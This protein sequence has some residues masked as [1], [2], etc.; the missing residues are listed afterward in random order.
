MQYTRQ[1]LEYMATKPNG[2]ATTK[3]LRKKF[4]DLTS[5][6]INQALFMMRKNGKATRIDWGTW[7]AN[8]LTPVNKSD[9]T[10]AEQAPTPTQSKPTTKRKPYNGVKSKEIDQLKKRLDEATQEILHWHKVV[11]DSEAMRQ[12][13]NKMS[14]D[15]QDALATIRYLE[16][17]L[18]IAIQHNARIVNGNP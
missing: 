13:F 17:K 4:R 5:K 14:G 2:T 6:Q 7:K 1:I 18:F 3:Q 11:K 10:S 12:Q 9:E 15:L 16:N 8:E